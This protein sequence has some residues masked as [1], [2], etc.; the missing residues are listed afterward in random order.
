MRYVKYQTLEEAEAYRE[1]LQARHD[2]THVPGTPKIIDCICPTYDGQFALTW[3]DDDGPPIVP[4]SGGQQ[5]HP[6]GW[7]PPPDPAHWDTGDGEVVDTLEPPQVEEGG[8]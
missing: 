5:T 3:Q 6:D 8:E 1:V 2:E 4:P 7:E